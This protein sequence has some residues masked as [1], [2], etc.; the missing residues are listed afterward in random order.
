MGGKDGVGGFD[1]GGV[2]PIAF[3]PPRS[4][5]SFFYLDPPRLD[6]N[7]NPTLRFGSVE[8]LADRISVPG[9][10]TQMVSNFEYRI[11]IV[12]PVSISL[13]FDAGINGILRRSQ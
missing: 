2:S 1:P 9:G 12:G 8:V 11:P 3:P 6:P 5:V 10:D 7:G 4:T 13:F